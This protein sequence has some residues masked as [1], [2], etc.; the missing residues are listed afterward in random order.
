MLKV[1]LNGQTV[2]NT[3]F[4]NTQRNVGLFCGALQVMGY[5]L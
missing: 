4:D 5:I 2:G 3:K 1:P